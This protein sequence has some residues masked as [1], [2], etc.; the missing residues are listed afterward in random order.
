MLTLVTGA[1][2][3]WVVL[4]LVLPPADVV[5]LAERV[6]LVL[7]IW[8]VVVTLRVVLEDVEVRVGVEGAVVEA[9]TM[10]LSV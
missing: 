8:F 1:P 10:V 2:E 5:V 7:E 9:W 3:L 6:V 4:L